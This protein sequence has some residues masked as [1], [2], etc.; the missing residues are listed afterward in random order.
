MNILSHKFWQSILFAS[1]LLAFSS[2]SSTSAQEQSQDD[3]NSTKENYFAIQAGY[4]FGDATMYRL[5]LLYSMMYG[6]TL[7]PLIDAELGVSFTG[8][9]GQSM[10]V[11]TQV[12]VNTNVD[13][14]CLFK[15]PSAPAL[16]IGAGLSLRQRQLYYAAPSLSSRDTE[17][18]YI[19]DLGIGG[20]GKID[21]VLFQ[22]NSLSL[23]TQLLG[24]V[25]FPFNGTYFFQDRP[26]RLEELT[27]PFSPFVVSASAFLRINF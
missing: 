22:S 8:R 25:F 23:G 9:D 1:I 6:R 13:M 20:H 5:G 11:F 21:Y 3:L 19:S 14:T 16:R 4:A 17:D 26:V 10:S 27:F 12:F 24:Q 15:F 18:R 2:Y 7:S